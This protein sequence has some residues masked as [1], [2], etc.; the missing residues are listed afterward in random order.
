MAAGGCPC[1]PHLANA[2][3]KCVQRAVQG[4]IYIS[5]TEKI[6]KFIVTFSQPMC[7]FEWIRGVDR[8]LE[9]AWAFISSSVGTPICL[10]WVGQRGSV[11]FFILMLLVASGMSYSEQLCASLLGNLV[12]LFQT[13]VF[14]ANLLLNSSNIISDDI[15]RGLP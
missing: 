15:I 14:L 10:A 6:Q 1:S 9:P 3:A 7:A 8:A 11:V 5:K 4:V 2:G 12:E 13:L